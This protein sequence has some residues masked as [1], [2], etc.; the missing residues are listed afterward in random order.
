MRDTRW[1]TDKASWVTTTPQCVYYNSALRPAPNY[2]NVCRQPGQDSTILAPQTRNFT[3]QCRWN[4]FMRVQT[5][6]VVLRTFHVLEETIQSGTSRLQSVA[7]NCQLPLTI[8]NYIYTLHLHSPP[9]ALLLT[10]HSR[11][12]L[13]KMDCKF[14][15]GLGTRFQRLPGR[16]RVLKPHKFFNSTRKKTATLT[17]KTYPSTTLC[18]ILYK[19]LRNTLTYL[20]LARLAF[21]AHKF[22]KL[23]LE[24]WFSSAVT[25]LQGLESWDSV[26]DQSCLVTL[27]TCIT[28]TDVFWKFICLFFTIHCTSHFM[29]LFF[30]HGAL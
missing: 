12:T 13:L 25:L 8:T 29:S 21:L 22:T 4:T 1:W 19:R 20:H 30:V 2:C 15:W 3:R 17:C 11:Q 23:L 27:L 5:P 28:I 18:D 6:C 9:V 7:M 14:L 10:I 16:N 26:G 24:I